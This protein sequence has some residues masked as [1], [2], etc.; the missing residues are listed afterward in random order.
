MKTGMDFNKWLRQG[1]PYMN[2]YYLNKLSDQLDRE[3]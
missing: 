2:D 1:I 3:I